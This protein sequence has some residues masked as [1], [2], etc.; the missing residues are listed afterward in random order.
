MKSFG[1]K[2]K[3]DSKKRFTQG[4]GILEGRLAW[5]WARQGNCPIPSKLGQG[6]I[7]GQFRE[8]QIQPTNDRLIMYNYELRN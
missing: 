5:M 6:P 2:F 3:A 8:C 4:T 1:W 7:D